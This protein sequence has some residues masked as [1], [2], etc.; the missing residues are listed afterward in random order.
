LAFQEM[1][2]DTQPFHVNTIDIACKKIL[3]RTEM[4][5]KGKSKDIII[6]NPHMS[7]I[8]QKEIARKAPDDKA[9]KS[10]GTK[11]QAQLMRQARQPDLSITDSLTPMCGRSDA[12]TDGPANSAGQSAYGQRRP[13]PHKALKGKETQEQSTYGCLIK[14]GPTFDQLLSKNTSKNTVLRDRS[15]KKP[16]L[17]AKTKRV[18]KTARKATQQASPIHPM[19]PG[20]FPPVYSLSVYYPVQIWNGTTMN[21]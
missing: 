16:R 4:A 20:Y 8:S 1:Q 12:Q 3:V 21:P 9:K 13:P 11:G 15:T 17:P 7:N 18:N 10:G 19:R 6:G 5:D 14:A 2:V